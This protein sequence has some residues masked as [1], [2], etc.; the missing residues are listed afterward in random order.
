MTS[1]QRSGL[2]PLCHAFSASSPSGRDVRLQHLEPHGLRVGGSRGWQP[3]P[4][5]PVTSAHRVQRDLRDVLR[6]ERMEARESDPVER[7]SAA[8]RPTD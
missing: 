4:I 5:N 7:L 2:A 3:I 1:R 8:R 6:R